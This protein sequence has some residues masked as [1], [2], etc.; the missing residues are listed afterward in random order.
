MG[1]RRNIPAPKSARIQKGIAINGSIFVALP[2][3]ASAEADFRA[4]LNALQAELDELDAKM[5]AGLAEWTG[6]ARAAYDLTHAAWQQAA[7]DMVK[8]LAL[9]QAV[10]GTAHMNYQSARTTNLRMWRGN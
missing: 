10:I 4:I 6:D 3:M 1:R 7:A 9:L 8:S 5:R 2:I